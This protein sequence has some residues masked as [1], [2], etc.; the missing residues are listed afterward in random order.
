M[1]VI[2]G[3]RELEKRLAEIAQ[4]ANRKA[5]VRVGFLENATYPDG[6]S[7]AMVAAIQDFGAP[8]RGIPPRPF[9]RNMVAEKSPTWG[10]S[11][12]KLL[13]ANDYDAVKTLEQVGAG[14]GGQLVQSIKDTNEPELAE[15]TVA[16]KGFKKPL[17]DTGHMQ[18]S[19][20]WE[21]TES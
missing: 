5:T 11:T 4:K 18:N 3:G 13:M 1:A 20:S 12:A 7:V 10:D 6:T 21:V 14:I 19:V 16:R 17:V 8:S 9:F 15:S 2:S